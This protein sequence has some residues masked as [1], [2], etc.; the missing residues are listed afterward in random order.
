MPESVATLAPAARLPCRRD[1]GPRAGRGWKKVSQLGFAEV[2]PRLEKRRFVES[3]VVRHR[4]VGRR[5][6]RGT[7]RKMRPSKVGP[8]RGAV[9][10]A[11]VEIPFEG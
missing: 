7:A 8:V 6:D 11:C 1:G 5:L 2:C 3:P 9:R 10:D 4:V